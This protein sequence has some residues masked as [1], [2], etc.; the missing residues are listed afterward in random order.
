ME[1]SALL[2][3]YDVGRCLDQRW[4]WRNLTFTVQ[5]GDRLAI[6]GA[7]GTGK[8]LLLRA[9]A[10][11]DP[12]QAG[13]IT[14]AGKSLATWAMPAYRARVIYLHQR[15]VLPEGTV[16]QM[17]RQVY[18]FASHRHMSYDRDRL[19]TYL[20]SLGRT[21]EFLNQ[22]TRSLSGGESQIAAF[23]RALQLSPDILLLDEPTAS[24]DLEA[25][26]QLEA[27]IAHWHQ[28]NP[29]RAYLWTSHSPE[30]IQRVTDRAIALSPPQELRYGVSIP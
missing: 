6:V 28:E 24:L 1:K 15:P 17:L 23:L 10:G 25:T 7:S 18:T 14:F 2:S 4:I 12:I 9:I 3:V 30:Q 29:Q 11:L 5:M 8:T 27:L 21:E 26:H 16:E 20:N 22:A 19:L 13:T